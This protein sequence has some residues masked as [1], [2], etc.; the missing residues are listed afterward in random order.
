MYLM[1]I[2]LFIQLG[3]GMLRLDLD[4]RVLGGIKVESDWFIVITKEVD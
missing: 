2:Y 1:F 3:I 4:S